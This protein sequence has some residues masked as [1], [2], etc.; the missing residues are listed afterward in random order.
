MAR[1]KSVT[2][3]H[4][5]ERLGLTIQTVSKALRGHPGMSEETRGLVIQTAAAMGYRTKEQLHQL[6]QERIAPFPSYTRRFILV[7]SEQ[8]LGFLRLLLQGLHERFA[9]YGHRMD[10][11]LLPETTS[12][13][14]FRRWLELHDVGFADGIF[15]APRI[16]P[17]FME[18]ILLELP[19]PRILLN[20]PPPETKV[21][22]VVWDVYEAMFVAVRTLVRAGHQRIMYVGDIHL[23]R[24]FILRWQAFQEAMKE[25]SVQVTEDGHAVA[26]RDSEKPWLD[27]FA[28]K[29]ERYKPT[30]VICGI[31]E[32]VAPVYYRLQAWT[33]VPEGCSLM[34]FLNEPIDHLPLVDRPALLIRE[35]GYRAAD[36]MLWRI[37]NPQQP[38]EHIRLKGDFVR[39]TTVVK[40]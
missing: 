22:S 20:F 18:Q 34:G 27:D 5:A 16:V 31:D 10:T 15:I 9:E 30:A 4:I 23:Q 33:K 25:V 28:V 38:Y 14:E 37:A 24:G 3:L 29:Y 17:G 1:K 13:A 6:E 36:R 21:D 7:Q 26:R 32:E 2:L 40:M 8:S 12:P 39:G 11:L 19:L 35:T